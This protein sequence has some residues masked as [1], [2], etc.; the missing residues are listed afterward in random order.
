[1]AD[2][3]KKKG[4]RTTNR[5]VHVKHLPYN[6]KN[7]HISKAEFI[8]RRKKEKMAQEAAEK[9]RLKSLEESGI[10]EE[11]AE[12]SDAA[13]EGNAKI[14]ALKTKIR[15][16]RGKNGKKPAVQKKKKK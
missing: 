8:E 11:Q 7:K 10:S 6:E 13:E 4:Y 5:E 12:R 3:D 15:E 16:V 14:D 9:A 2:K 1:M